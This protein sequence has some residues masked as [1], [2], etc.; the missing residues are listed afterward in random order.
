MNLAKTRNEL[1][2]F[3]TNSKIKYKKLSKSWNL[4]MSRLAFHNTSW[5]IYSIPV[6]TEW[7]NVHIRFIVDVSWSMYWREY[8]IA[9]ETVLKLTELFDWLVSMDYIVFWSIFKKVDRSQ[10][11]WDWLVSKFYC[12][13]S[14]IVKIKWVTSLLPILSTYDELKELWFTISTDSANTYS[15]APIKQSIEDLKELE[16]DKII[17]FLTDWKDNMSR[18]PDEVCWISTSYSG[19]YGKLMW[20]MNEAWIW[21]LPLGIDTDMKH[22]KWIKLSDAEEIYPIILNFLKDKYLENG[23]NI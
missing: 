4:E 16:W 23:K 3:F 12:S 20:E 5:L 19:R 2:K 15:P 22:W 14:P 9:S 18:K 7:R 6:D 8:R 21:F 11:K 17:I 1:V 10:L 13:Q